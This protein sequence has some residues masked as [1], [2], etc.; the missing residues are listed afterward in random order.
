M[1]D[2][3]HVKLVLRSTL[4]GLILGLSSVSQAF[5]LG[6]LDMAGSATYVAYTAMEKAEEIAAE[7][8]NEDT[9]YDNPV[10][11]SLNFKFHIEDDLPEQDVFIERPANSGNVYRFGKSE[12]DLSL[13]LYASKKRIPHNPFGED[14]N[15]PYEK[16]ADLGLTLKEWFSAEGS[17]TYSCVNGEGNIKAQFSGLVPDAMYTVW[18]FFM[19]MPPTQP[20]IGT[21]DLPMGKRDGS[22]SMFTTDKK[23]AA[24]Y[25]RNFRPCLQLSGEHLDSGLAVAWHSDGKTYG[26]EPGDFGR[27]THIQLYTF[28][29]KRS[30]L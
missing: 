2:M 10:E 27:V 21:H 29:P 16:G 8:T 18:H 20:F 28:L 30:G 5:S 15:G 23:G 25:E 22:Q 24:S 13:P 6:S 17:A 7:T 4:L 3:R 19:A 26:V 14:A 11:L 12:K 9:G 1:N